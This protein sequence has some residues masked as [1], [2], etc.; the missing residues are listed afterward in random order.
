MVKTEGDLNQE[1]GGCPE[2]Q[3]ASDSPVDNA[4]DSDE[5]SLDIEAAIKVLDVIWFVTYEFFPIDCFDI[6]MSLLNSLNF[7]CCL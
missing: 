6:F 2:S 5:D 3:K 1:T 7:T 4:S